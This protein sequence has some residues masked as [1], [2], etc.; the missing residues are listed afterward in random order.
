MFESY[1]VDRMGLSEDTD[2]DG[3]HVAGIEGIDAT[4]YPF[5][6]MAHVDTGLHLRLRYQPN[7]FRSEFAESVAAR[8]ARVVQIM[9]SDIDTPIAHLTLL[10]EAELQEYTAVSGAPAGPPKTLPE[11]LTAS[12][13]N[14]PEAPALVC[15]GRETSYR[16][17]D[18]RSN[19]AGPGAHRSRC[20]AGDVRGARDAAIDRE[21]VLAVWAVAKAGAAF[22]PVDP[23]YPRR[24]H[25]A[26]ADRFRCGTRSDR[27]PAHR[28]PLART[29]CRGWCSTIR[30]F[31][32]TS[33]R[34][35]AGHRHRPD[36]RVGARHR[37]RRRT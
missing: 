37:P 33:G 23:N 17:L 28:A 31:D 29:P 6:L 34:R 15:D 25:R 12:A 16:E 21:S 20:R 1:P 13:G 36:R 35:I 10:S 2:I 32:R 7:V 5:T 24:P 27:R 22:V 30:A 11:I 8:V 19:A 9:L 26:H 3:M 18:E 14:R 4:H